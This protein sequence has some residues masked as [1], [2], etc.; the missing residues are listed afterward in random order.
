MPSNLETQVAEAKYHVDPVSLRECDETCPCDMTNLRWP[1]LSRE[2][3][4][5]ESW[6]R[7]EHCN[8]MGVHWKSE[9]CECCHGSG[10]IPDVTLMK[11]LN[12]L[13][14]G[15]ALEESDFGYVVKS[16]GKEYHDAVPEDAACAAL[17]TIPLW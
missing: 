16:H 15:W 17:L 8:A 2:C 6:T 13:P 11:A 10:R 12:L 9:L 5:L 3:P 1:V 4:C 7:C 14:S